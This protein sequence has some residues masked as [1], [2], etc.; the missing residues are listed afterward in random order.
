MGE[1]PPSRGGIPSFIAQLL[2]DPTLRERFDLTWLNTTHGY[3]RT[4][5]SWSRENL[6]R[7]IRDMDRLARASRSADIVHLHVAPA[8]LAPLLRTLLLS[9]AARLAGAR[10]VVHGH[11]GRIHRSLAHPAYR[12]A[13]LLLARI[14]SEL[15]VVSARE[16][17]ALTP[18]IPATLIANGIDVTRWQPEGQDD[19]QDAAPDD[20]GAPPVAVYVGT[21]CERKGLM[22]LF[23]A[24]TI[25]RSRQARRPT[26]GARLQPFP[27]RHACTSWARCLHP[28]CAG[29]FSALTCSSC[30]RT[31][32]ASR[33]RC[34]RPWPVVCPSW[35]P[36]WAISRRCWRTGRREWSYRRTPPPHWP[37]RSIA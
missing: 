15:I 20:G 11:S 36:M 12:I 18:R 23:A 25:A 29:G 6:R 32:R 30:L 3:E 35:Q 31:G 16:R 8:P 27:T 21:V 4:P 28:T 10:V 7:V 17:D 37:P 2:Q 14:S 34:W 22:D 1:G 26:S 24:A 19:R 13:M 9:A 33:S 5:G